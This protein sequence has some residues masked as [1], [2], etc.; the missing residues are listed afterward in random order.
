MTDA[1]YIF[2]PIPSRRLGRSL[3]VSPVPEKTCNYTCVYCQLGRT[4]HM[5][6]ERRLFY[7]VDA[8]I[9]ELKTFLQSG[10]PFDVITVV[11]EGEPT[12][13]SALG[14]LIGHIKLLS[15]AP[16]AVITNGALMG[17]KAVR[18]D[19]SRADIVLPSLDAFDEESWKK[20]NRPYPRLDFK[21]ALE[22]LIQFGSEYAGEIWLEI[23]LVEGI[24][25]SDAA[26]AALKKLCGSIRHDRLYINTAVRPP[27]ENWAKPASAETVQK[28]AA[29]L[30]GISIDRLSDGGFYSNIEDI[31]EAVISII[32]RHP[33]NRFEIQSFYE[34]RRTSDAP[35]VSA[36]SG[37]DITDTDTRT[38]R[39]ENPA[40]SKAALENIF[41]RLDTDK[42][43]VPSVY[44]GIVTYRLQ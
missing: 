43:V 13:Y 21:A 29:L 38:N 36:K 16:V 25:T 11:G 8:I 18:E 40:G 2:G 42:R 15:Q 27:A 5:I 35:S 19:L 7:P 1:Q 24:N 9:G 23:M 12:L 33:M 32:R 20:I 37:T 39:A 31:Y 34:S 10:I 3:G 41:S 6:N 44:K 17:D 30:N 14:E 28:A 26:L 22:G 4:A